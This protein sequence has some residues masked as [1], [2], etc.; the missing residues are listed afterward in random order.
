M[1]AIIGAMESEVTFYKKNLN[2]ISIKNILNQ[3][4]YLGEI[5]NNKVVVTKCGIGKVSSS[6]V[7]SLVIKEFNPKLI[8]NTGIAGGT[9]PL[10]TGDI[11]IANKYVYGDFD[12]K[13]FGYHKGQV[14]GC[15]Q[16]FNASTEHS[17]SFKT[18]LKNSNI[19]FN[20]G[21]IITQDSFITSLS[22]IND[23]DYVGV[24]TDMEGA[25]MAHVCMFHNIPFFS[26]R[27]I[28]DVIG[29]DSQVNNYDKFEIEAAKLSSEITFKFLSK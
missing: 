22:Q 29:S 16:Y 10:N 23:F 20:E 1:I 28:S 18:Y 11:F 8:I 13:V 19:K 7:T 15:E 14:P 12:L 5:G 21:L 2:N 27:I 25:S 26:V 17:S 6:I 24:A 3:E 4:F 9:L